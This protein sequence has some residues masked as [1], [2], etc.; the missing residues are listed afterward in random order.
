MG[1]GVERTGSDRAVRET[2]LTGALVIALYLF[3][4]LCLLPPLPGLD[5]PLGVALVAGVAGGVAQWL[6][7]FRKRS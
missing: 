3:F 2:F 5:G 1:G 6:V 7:N 4:R